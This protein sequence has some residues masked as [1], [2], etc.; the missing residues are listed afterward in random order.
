MKGQGRRMAQNH[1]PIVHGFRQDGNPNCA[2]LCLDNTRRWSR[3]FFLK[4][5]E[6]VLNI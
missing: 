5:V 2:F 6:F 3:F 1:T 4:C